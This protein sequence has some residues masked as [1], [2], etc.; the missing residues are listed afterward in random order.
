MKMRTGLGS[1]MFDGF[2]LVFMV[3]LMAVTLYPILYV[4]FASFSNPTAVATSSGILWH[5]VD[6]TTA[7][8]KL[9]FQNKNI[10][11]GFRNTLTYVS[12]GTI[13][14]L[15]STALAAYTLSRKGP[16]WNKLIMMMIVVTMFFGGGLIP[17]FLLIKKL[18]MINTIWAIVLPPMISAYNIIVMK[19]FFQGISNE[20]IESAKMDGANDLTVFFRIVMPVSWAVISVI[21]LFYAVSEW[22]SWFAAS[23]YL[24]DRELYPM[25]LYLR[26]ILVQN[27]V[28]FSM[29]STSDMDGI[30]A[31][32]IIKY[33]AIIVTTLPILFVYPFL[34]KYF[35]K[36]VMI[37]SLK[38]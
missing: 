32:Q 35:V 12:V 23:I 31:K 24:R 22:N 17:M 38:E 18:G 20:L 29:V 28:D 11:H 3:V 30:A 1:K 25:Q 26:E 36:G 5:P 16:L 37:G 19:T 15:S 7:G 13:L 21:G 27:K 4:L 9:V 6:F 2:N 8:Y 14:S 34:Q 10:W 33:A